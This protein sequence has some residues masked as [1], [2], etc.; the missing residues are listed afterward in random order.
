MQA[1]LTEPCSSVSV[2]VSLTIF[3]PLA[4]ACSITCSI[5]LTVNATSLTPSP[6]RT[7]C[8]PYS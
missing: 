8:S 3:P 5:L 4:R 1:I 7:R 2:Q 6:C